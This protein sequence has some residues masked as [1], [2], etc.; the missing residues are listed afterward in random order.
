MLSAL[1]STQVP[2]CVRGWQVSFIYRSDRALNLAEASLVD[3]FDLA[4]PIVRM[5]NWEYHGTRLQHASIG[6]ARRLK[7][8]GS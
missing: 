1:L 5:N 6:R 4:R 2:Y 8:S 7:I 3:L